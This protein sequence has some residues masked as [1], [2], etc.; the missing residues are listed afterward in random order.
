VFEVLHRSA[1]GRIGRWTVDG[2]VLDTPA[3]AFVDTERFPAPPWAEAVA[4]RREPPAGKFAF[5]FAGSFF[6]P[7]E[8][9]GGLPLPPR[10]G[11]SPSVSSIDLPHSPVKGPIAVVSSPGQLKPDAS[12]ETIVLEG[13]PV[14]LERA[15]D[16]VRTVVGFRETFGPA[17]LL[18]VPGIAAPEI[19]AVLVYA[20]VDVIDSSRVAM[21]TALGFYETPD[22]AVPRES[23]QE[24][25]CRCPSC[26]RGGPL[27]DHNYHAL[28][29]ELATARMAIR[30][31]SLRELAERRSVNTPWATAVLRE[32]DLRHHEFQERW[33]PVSDG[34]VRAYSPQS[35]SRPDVV[36][37]RR[38]VTIEYEKPPSARI[39]LFLPCSARKPYAESKT[40][41][42]FRR[43]VEAA[44]NANAVHEVIVT[45]PLGLVP[46]ELE[47]S[48]P[49]AHYDIPVTGDWSHDETAMLSEMLTSYL[50]RNRYDAVIAHVATE[51]PFVAAA[52]PGAEF[53]SGN[54]PA[55]DESL[56]TLTAALRKVL[57]GLPRVRSFV[58]RWEDVASLARFQFGPVGAA[59]MDGTSLRG[60]WPFA[61]LIRGGTQ[62][63]AI[64]ERGL[65]ALSLAGG[66]VLR[67]KGAFCVE[68]E[69]FH[70]KGNIFAIGVVRASPEIRVG[71][72]VAVVHGDQVRAIGMARMNAREMVDF[73]RGEAVRV[74]HRAPASKP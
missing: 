16:F 53:T 40:H 36:R 28:W 39:L 43:A 20:G 48:Y 23:L 35:L 10:S 13:G 17:R 22:G 59:M 64:A 74:R 4:T 56:A 63:G 45:S 7:A 60:R 57:E 51:A 42:R 9:H 72:E 50:A 44:G 46:R 19:V 14:F 73:R 18:F 47:R 8:T 24:L 27:L 21:E 70:P 12:A 62:L 25:P 5:A 34:L 1:M 32:L 31:G 30:Q 71:S 65:I 29:Q 54:H 33:F 41:R 26:E 49:A 37:F 52:V 55:S 58:G 61:R 15:K 6:E 3:I 68:I 69:D 38:F 11:L 2:R 66:E 67:E